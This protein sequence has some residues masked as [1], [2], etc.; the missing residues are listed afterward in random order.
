MLFTEIRFICSDI[1]YFHGSTALGGPGPH[2][3]HDFTITLR[4]TTLGRTPP[5]PDAE[6]ST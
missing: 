2:D 6:T 4:H 5:Q 3:Y 1:F